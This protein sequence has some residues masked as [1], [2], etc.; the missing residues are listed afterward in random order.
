MLANVSASSAVFVDEN[1]STLKPMTW[2]DIRTP[3][4]TPFGS[5]SSRQMMAMI[6]AVKSQGRMKSARSTLRMIGL[7]S[8][9]FKRSAKAMPIARW[10]MTLSAVK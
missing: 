7:T 5:S 6:T 1:H 9:L 2:S 3:L 10:K 4:I 8:R